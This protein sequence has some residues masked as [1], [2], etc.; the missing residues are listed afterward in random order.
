ML[1]FEF[2]DAWDTGYIGFYYIH[3]TLDP[4]RPNTLK[5]SCTVKSCREYYIKIYRDKINILPAASKEFSRMTALV[6]IGRPYAGSYDRKREEFIESCKRSIFILNSFEKHHRWPLTHMHHIQ[7]KARIPSM[8]FS[9][10]RRWT[11]SPYLMSIWTFAI[12]IGRHNWMP[13]D[14][15]KLNHKDLVPT[16]YKSCDKEKG[17]GGDAYQLSETVLEWDMVM[18]LY[19]ELFGCHT[20]KYNWDK[21]HLDG[22]PDRPEGILKLLTGTS[23]NK[24]LY[25]RYKR[26]KNQKEKEER[27]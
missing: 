26:L 11:M 7:S 12:R 13:K 23:P 20:R 27:K 3:T 5:S 25:E 15:Y 19:K 2:G 8:F 10:N 22:K 9:G 1:N 21:C 16:L 4:Q 24:S 6:T 17:R 18:S 14:L